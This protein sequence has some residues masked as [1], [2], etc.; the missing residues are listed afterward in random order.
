LALWLLPSA[1]PLM[2]QLNFKPLERGE[3]T[4]TE[5]KLIVLRG[6]DVG[7]DYALRA[8]EQ[9]SS[10]LTDLQRNT[11]VDQ[12]FRLNFHTLFHRDVA[13][14]L[15]VQTGRTALDSTNLRVPQAGDRG[16]MIDGEPITLT[17]REAYLRYDFNPNSHLLFGKHELSLGDRR[18]KVLNVIAPGVTFDCRVGT[19]CMPFGAVRVGSNSSDWTYHWALDYRAWDEPQN[20][21]R[22]VL[23]VEIFRIMYTEQNIPLAKNLGPGAWRRNPNDDP[24][25]PTTAAPAGLI[26]EDVAPTSAICGARCAKRPILYDAHEQNYFGLRA[27]WEASAF[28]W[29][30]DITSAQGNRKY[31]LYSQDSGPLY[32]AGLGQPL[33]KQTQSGIAMESEIGFRWLNGRMGLRAMHAT[34]DPPAM[35]GDGSS[36]PNGAGYLR[37]LRGY[38]EIS[39]GT[40]RGTR[41]YFNGA[42]GQVELGGGLGH[43]INNKRVVGFFL[44]L[45]YPETTRVGYSLGLHQIWLNEAVYNQAGE[46]K[47]NV[48]FEWD[49][50][51]TWHI[52]K[53]LK[54]QAEANLLQAGGAF[55]LND[56]TPP[57]SLQFL[58]VQAIG[59]LVYHF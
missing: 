21:L 51:L 12:D 10:G 22:S 50:M 28:F 8:R 32:N 9:K 39:P 44:D 41:L 6:L 46:L 23:E 43:S 40:Y 18:G 17:A 33:F 48:G 56:T 27:N 19:W 29:N 45:D 11:E 47:D 52:H 13:M 3:V 16:G 7:G 15:T 25:A 37:S 58:F 55:A 35:L 1:A 54:F 42:D 49:N 31:H 5:E 36:L 53:A 34:G 30:F 59:R 26:T 24:S 2:A 14:H 57:E 38:Y 4:E 20:G